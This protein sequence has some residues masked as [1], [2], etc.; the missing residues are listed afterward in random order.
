MD[1]AMGLF[2]D[3]EKQFDKTAF[4][5]GMAATAG[6]VTPTNPDQPVFTEAPQPPPPS[7]PQEIDQ[8]FDLGI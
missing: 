2:E 3:F 7:N 1:S 6:G 8:N 5:K 4:V